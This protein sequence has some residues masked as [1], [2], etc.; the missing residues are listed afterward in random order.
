MRKL[1]LSGLIVI[2]MG[3]AGCAKKIPV[4]YG[5]LENGSLVYITLT[6]N[7]TIKGEIQ[8]KKADSIVLIPWK[9]QVPRTIA[10]KKIISIKKKPSVYDEA[11]VVI[12]ESEIQKRQSHQNKWLYS[13]GGSA[14]SF[15]VSFFLTANILHQTSNDTEGASL[16]A[17][18]IGGTAIGGLLFGMKGNDRD[19]RTSIEQIREKRKLNALKKRK[20]TKK[21]HKDIQKKLDSVKADREKQNDEINRLLKQINKK[22]KK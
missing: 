17:P 6:S 7:E 9:S 4:T 15:G 21:K 5:N 1:F 19:R 13:L 11:N 2:I 16:W 22:K 12:P 3:L 18:T 10:R 14:L 20:T 8:Q